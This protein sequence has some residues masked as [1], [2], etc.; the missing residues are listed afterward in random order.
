[1]NG[2]MDGEQNP[3][4]ISE[5]FGDDTESPSYQKTHRPGNEGEKPFKVQE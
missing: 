1:M 4:S 5:N 3:P 2:I